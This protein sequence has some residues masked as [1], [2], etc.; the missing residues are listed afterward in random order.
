[1]ELRKLSTLILATLF[2]LNLS[3]IGLD[4]IFGRLLNSGESKKQRFFYVG[5]LTPLPM[6]KDK[7]THI[8]VAGSAMDVDSDQFFQSALLKAKIYQSLYPGH[9]IILVSQL[10]VIKA[11]GSEVFGRY[12]VKVVATEQGQL[13]QKQLYRLMSK[14]NKIASF[15]FYGHSSP[16]GL[17][18]GHT[19]ASM[20]PVSAWKNLRDKFMPNA[21][22]SLNGCNTG[23]I[24]A[25]KLSE[26]WNI[27]VNGNLTGSV[28][29][30]IQAD[31]HW[32][33]KIDRS[34]SE[35]VSENRVNFSEAKHCYQGVCW[36]MKAQRHNY[37]SYWGNFKDG[38][39]SFPKTFC[40]FEN[41]SKCLSAMRISL[42]THPSVNLNTLNPSRKE[43]EDKVFD[44]LCST[45]KDPSYFNE[46]REGI[47]KAVASGEHKF[48]M[49]PGN[50][51]HCDLKSCHAEVKCKT[52]NTSDGFRPG[53]CYIKTKVNDNPT[54]LVREYLLY[55]E[56]FSLR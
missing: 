41:K 38:G 34:S 49:H 26:L 6:D 10:D 4:D 21:Y 7:P 20:Y 32:Y 36:R 39:L 31:Q 42:L 30:R 19:K 12:G 40:N 2:S 55:M 15:D 3:A 1:M 51:L 14:F 18:L 9:Q 48:K 17:R 45:H 46:C 35:Y 11:S 43:Y 8:L 52:G 53:S 54:T 5:S 28:F 24:I 22:A 47:L 25:P 29:E 50:A 13:V 16:W 37:S 33:K 44:I 27:P 56:A 23:F